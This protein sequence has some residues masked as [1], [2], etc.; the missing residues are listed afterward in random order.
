VR[1]L[2]APD[3]CS[4]AEAH[5]EAHLRS[6]AKP[7]VLDAGCGRRPQLGLRPSAHVVGLDRDLGEIA[8]NVSIDEAITGDVQTHRFATETFDVVVCTYVLEH[9]DRP[10]DALENLL[11][12]LKPGGLLVVAIS[13][14]W[15]LK[16]IVAKWTPQRIHALLW[17]RAYPYEQSR[18]DPFPTVLSGA[19]RLRR[20]R[21]H[22]QRRGMT[23]VDEARYESEMQVALRRKI[24]LVGGR[25]HAA[26]LGVRVVTLGVVDPVHSDLMLV[27]RKV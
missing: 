13:N 5:V 25:W 3:A 20:L 15:S 17:H 26:A 7:R 12:A 18:R 16:A 24:R 8:A 11:H 22:L 27:L 9:V 1:T 10:L 4:A 19:L 14:V 23:V 2:D 21:R 6:V